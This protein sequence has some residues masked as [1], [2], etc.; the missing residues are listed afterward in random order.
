MPTLQDVL[1]EM[2][3]A[4]EAAHQHA[5]A[6]DEANDCDADWCEMIDLLCGIEGAFYSLNEQDAIIDA[7]D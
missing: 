7:Q 6:A 4:I 2:R 1:T 3:D 5:A